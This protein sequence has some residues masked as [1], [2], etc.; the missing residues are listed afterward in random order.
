M[1]CDK[2]GAKNDANAFKCT[3][4]AH[5]LPRE[6]APAASTEVVQNNLA[7]SILVT[8]CCCMP[9]GIVAIIY[10]A[11]VNGKL[12]AGDVEGARESAKNAQT[13]AYWAF[14]LGIFAGI[15]QF[16]LAIAGNAGK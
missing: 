2:C 1:Y 9:L 6:G 16:I 12:A 8:L 7:Q 13:W 3:Q 4:C 11:Q 15:I 10:S 5:T 14:G